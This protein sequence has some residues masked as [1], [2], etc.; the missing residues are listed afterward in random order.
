MTEKVCPFMSRPVVSGDIWKLAEVP[1]IGER[2][3]A[4]GAKTQSGVIKGCMLIP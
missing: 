3:E 1:C 2:C 4:W